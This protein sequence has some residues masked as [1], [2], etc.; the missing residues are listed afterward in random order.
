[1]FAEESSLHVEGVSSADLDCDFLC[2]LNL[3]SCRE[4]YKWLRLDK[5][6]AWEVHQRDI[7]CKNKL[8][9]VL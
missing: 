2:Q 6:V 8:N 4:Q 1:M 9:T 5:V 7:G 3:E